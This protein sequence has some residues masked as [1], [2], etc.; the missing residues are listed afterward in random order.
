MIK[1]TICSTHH[2]YD[3]KDFRQ[4][5]MWVERMLQMVEEK[6]L[7]DQMDNLKLDERMLVVKYD[8]DDTNVGVT[9]YFR[10][11]GHKKGVFTQRLEERSGSCYH[12]SSLEF[13]YE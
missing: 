10:C 5:K 11:T 7:K 1:Y 4:K 13:T 9:H 6:G 2:E 12:I 3:A 8:M